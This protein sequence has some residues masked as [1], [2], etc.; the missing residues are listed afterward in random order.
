VLALKNKYDSEMEFIVADVTKPQ[1]NSLA[2]KFDIYYIPVFFIL[3]SNGKI[4]EHIEFPQIQDNP[5]QMLDSF[6]AKALQKSDESPGKG[7]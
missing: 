4:L 5:Q 1:G 2:E 7:R 3:D 6:I